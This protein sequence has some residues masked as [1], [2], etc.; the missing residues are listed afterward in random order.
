MALNRDAIVAAGLE[1]LDAYG[2]GDLSMRRVAERLGVQPGALYY[3]VPNKQSMLA[4]IA[5]RI[6]GQMPVPDP[7][8]QTSSW[9][10]E[11]AANLRGAVLQCRDGAEL[12]ASTHAL[13]LG[14]V[15][16][17][18]EGAALLARQGDPSPRGSIGTLTHFV[19]GH[20]TTEQTRRQLHQMG[21]LDLFDADAAQRDFDHGVTL[22]I[23]G[24]GA[25]GTN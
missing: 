2:L 9:L 1:I 5:D 4:A 6:L 17:G 23:R 18:R 19:L 13:G 7:G 8:L 3:H 11:W 14:D 21:V 25:A 15:D 12:V 16:P 22:I 20:A 10:G 24:M